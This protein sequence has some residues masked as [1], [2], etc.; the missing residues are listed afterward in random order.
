M[1]NI[2][3]EFDLSRD[4]DVEKVHFSVD[5][6]EFTYVIAIWVDI[7]EIL[8]GSGTL[9]IIYRAS[10]INFAILCIPFWYGTLYRLST[11]W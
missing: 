4:I 10:V 6:N 7:W 11:E 9:R 5:C 1:T 8:G 3:L 2:H